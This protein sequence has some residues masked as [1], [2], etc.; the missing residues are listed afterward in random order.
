MKLK[1]IAV[2][3]MSAISLLGQ[4][5]TPDVGREFVTKVVTLTYP[6]RVS[7]SI[8]DGIGLIVKR[9]E[10]LVAI[11]G[12]RDRVEM[13]EA[14]L[15]QLDVPATPRAPVPP[16]KDIQ[17]TAYL[18][19]ASPTGTQTTPLPKEL[20]SAVNQ[21]A[22]IMPY[23]SF[24]LF[25]A[26]IMR[27]SDGSSGYVG[28]V[29]PATQ[30]TFVSGGSFIFRVGRAELTPA[31]PANLLRLQNVELSVSIN[32]GTDREGKD[33]VQ[34]VNLQTSI[35]MKE[36]QKVVVGKANIDGSENALLVILTAQIV[37]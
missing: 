12:P 5:A 37:D 8:I 6:E 21:V 13:A 17:F 30:Q 9:S 14:I 32:R 16:K 33:K 35:D 23:K 18:I 20:E 10:N 24:H 3:F 7:T 2:V 25:D 4:A 31:T 11:T 15:H 27:G 19:I 29:L 22:S 36:G 26:V 34:M 28:G 1:M